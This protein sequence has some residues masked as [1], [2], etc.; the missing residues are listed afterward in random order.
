MTQIRHLIDPEPAWTELENA[1][2]RL[3]FNQR[4]SKRIAIKRDRLLISMA[5]ALDG[6][7]C[8]TRKLRPVKFGDHG[9]PRKYASKFPRRPVSSLQSDRARAPILSPAGFFSPGKFLEWC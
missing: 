9:I 5:W 3:F 2:V 1:T 6:D 8:S 7:V 4:K